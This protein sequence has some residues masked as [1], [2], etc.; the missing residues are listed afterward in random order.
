MILSRLVFYST[1]SWKAG[2][3]EADDRVL[4]AIL[5]AGQRNNPRDGLTGVLIVDDA[6][7]VQVMEGPRSTLTAT[8]RRIANDPRHTDIVLAGMAEISARRYD[9]W[10]VVVRRWPGRP[11]CAPWLRSPEV[12]PFKA[13]QVNA[14]RMLS[15]NSLF[16]TLG[17]L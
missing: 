8:F 16:Q 3:G 13:F 15:G 1:R 5:E 9:D 6:L 12:T 4:S 2:Q 10:N 14:E 7:L 11:K 17:P